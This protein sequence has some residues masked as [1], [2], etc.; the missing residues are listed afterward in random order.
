MNTG[1]KW[2]D[3]AQT[4]L[5]WLTQYPGLGRSGSGPLQFWK[6]SSQP[7]VSA[8]LWPPVGWLWLEKASGCW[9]QTCHRLSKIKKGLNKRTSNSHD[10]TNERHLHELVALAPEHDSPLGQDDLGVPVVLVARRDQADPALVD[11]VVGLA[12]ALPVGDADVA[13]SSKITALVLLLAQGTETGK[14]K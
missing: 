3:Q 5:N 1:S 14:G 12:P 4:V 8:S 7:P 10:S 13:K 2:L 6:T 11:G 9:Q